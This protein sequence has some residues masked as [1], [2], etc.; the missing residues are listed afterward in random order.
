M[1]PL[2]HPVIAAVVMTGQAVPL[3]TKPSS[4][5][6]LELR[7]FK[8]KY[9]HAQLYA[10]LDLAFHIA[11]IHIPLAL[12]NPSLQSPDLARTSTRE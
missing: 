12:F 9:E 10:E 5:V 3:N 2:P 1:K 11:C 8:E 7:D 4:H 6:D